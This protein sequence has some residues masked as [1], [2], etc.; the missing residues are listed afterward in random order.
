MSNNPKTN[1]WTGPIPPLRESATMPS[2]KVRDL[3]AEQAE[4]SRRVKR[5]YVARANRG[6]HKT[7]KACGGQKRVTNPE[8]GSMMP[9]PKCKNRKEV[10]KL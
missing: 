1:R 5:A 9:C 2:K 4:R 3:F 7:C 8:N 6:K 10:V